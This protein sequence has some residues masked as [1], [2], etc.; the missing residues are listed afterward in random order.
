MLVI[1]IFVMVIMKE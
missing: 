1:N